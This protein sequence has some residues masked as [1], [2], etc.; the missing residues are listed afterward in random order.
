MCFLVIV[1]SSLPLP[2]NYIIHNIVYKSM[3]F[4]NFF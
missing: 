4:I 3:V 1:F 2:Y